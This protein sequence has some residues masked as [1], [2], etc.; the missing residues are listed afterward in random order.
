M[1]L[2]RV[3]TVTILRRPTKRYETELLAIV[4]FLDLK[5]IWE[6]TISHP[7]S[8]YSNLNH[9]AL[10][11]NLFETLSHF[12]WSRSDCTCQKKSKTS[13][14]HWFSMGELIGQNCCFWRERLAGTCACA[15]PKCEFYF[16]NSS[17]N[18][19]IEMLEKL[20]FLLPGIKLLD[21][22]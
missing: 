8:A 11:S 2:F 15:H 20:R 9:L 10:T 17:A 18:Q 22:S 12:L 19:Q 14:H 7:V 4:G 16:I 21:S 13:D 1:L 5:S 3:Q 6:R